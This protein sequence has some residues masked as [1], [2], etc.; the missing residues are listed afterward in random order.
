M[1]DSPHT[2]NLSRSGAGVVARSPLYGVT[3]SQLMARAWQLARFIGR[4]R[5]HQ[6]RPFHYVARYAASSLTLNS[7]G[8]GTV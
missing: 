4:G 6:G 5:Q 2:T 8:P 3:R 1:A 7:V